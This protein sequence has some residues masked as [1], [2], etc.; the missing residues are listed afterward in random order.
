DPN[1]TAVK[2]ARTT[3]VANG[4]TDGTN[5]TVIVR[6]TGQPPVQT[7]PA[8][9]EI[10]N[11]VNGVQVLKQGYVEVTINVPQ[12]QYFSQIW[13]S[14]SLMLSARAVARGKYTAA[15]PGILVLDTNDKGTLDVAG[16][17]NVVVRGGGAI[18][19]NSSNGSGGT[20]EGNGFARAR[21]FNFSGKPG[22]D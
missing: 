7:S 16:T 15:N 18:I 3:A 10:T 17:G 6:V 14:R 4:F 5:A 9:V 20:S 1:G 8:V 22:Y 11:T 2:S 21:T 12:K 19:V 13:G